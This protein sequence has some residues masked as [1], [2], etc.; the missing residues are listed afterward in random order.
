M[1]AASVVLIAALVL[2]SFPSRTLQSQQDRITSA[3][4][5]LLRSKRLKRHETGGS[6]LDLASDG[7]KADGIWVPVPDDSAHQ[8]V[9]PEQTHILCYKGDPYCHEVEISFVAVADVISA[10][11]PEETLWTIK[12][13]DKNSLLAEWGPYPQLTRS[14]DK[15]QKHILSIVFASGTVTTSDIPTHGPECEAFKETNTYRLVSGYYVVDTSPNN[16]A[17]KD[18][19][20]MHE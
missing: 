15:C 11:G 20:A 16:D 12:S 10:N 3:A 4:S 18:D 2:G 6:P 13:W 7:I 17:M 8:L 19:A 9:F 1:N 14:E 5:K